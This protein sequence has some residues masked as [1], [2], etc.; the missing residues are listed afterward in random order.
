MVELVSVLQPRYQGI[1]HDR[2][3]TSF[4]PRSEFGTCMKFSV[5]IDSTAST[6]SPIEGRDE[7]GSFERKATDEWRRLGDSGRGMRWRVTSPLLGF[8]AVSSTLIIP[9]YFGATLI[10]E[11]HLALAVRPLRCPMHSHGHVFTW[12][13]H[14]HI[15]S[16][17]YTA[18]HTSC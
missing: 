5:D 11:P 16:A 9:R 15:T 3:R 7:G 13:S 8:S 2:L 4:Q 12:P 10:T 18:S 14:V 17:W 6:A 1:R